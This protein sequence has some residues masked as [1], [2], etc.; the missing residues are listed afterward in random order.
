MARFRF[1]FRRVFRRVGNAE[2]DAMA[3]DVA[4]LPR[5]KVGGRAGGSLFDKIRKLKPRIR[6]WGYVIPYASLRQ[7]FWWLLNGA[8]R[9]KSRQVARP[10]PDRSAE[11]VATLRE[12][13]RVSASEQVAKF[14]RMAVA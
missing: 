9:R 10:V 12:E 2:I 8:V 14:D 7:A 6:V 4:A 5:P 11:F 3:R 1:D 13:V